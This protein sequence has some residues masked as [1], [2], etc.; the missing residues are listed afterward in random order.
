MHISNAGPHQP[1]AA[2]FFN[3]Q[4]QIKYVCMYK[5]KLKNLKYLHPESLTCEVYQ[6]Q[7]NQ[8]K[9]FLPQSLRTGKI[10]DKM[11][12]RK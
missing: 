7:E 5:I 1:T 2:S 10:I 8:V 9:D 3:L 11:Q 6:K 4:D 12:Q